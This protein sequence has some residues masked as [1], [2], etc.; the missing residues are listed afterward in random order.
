MS[1]WTKIALDHLEASLRASGGA[2]TPL[3]DVVL[4]RLHAMK[5]LRKKD[6]LRCDVAGFRLKTY[7]KLLDQ[8]M[9]LKLA[10]PPPK[11]KFLRVKTDCQ[12]RAIQALWQDLFPDYV[13]PPSNGRRTYTPSVTPR[14]VL[15]QNYRGNLQRDL[16]PMTTA[17]TPHVSHPPDQ[18]VAQPGQLSHVPD[19]ASPVMGVTPELAEP[20]SLVWVPVG[21]PHGV[22]DPFGAQAP[23]VQPPTYF[24]GWFAPSSLAYPAQP[25]AGLPTIPSKQPPLHDSVGQTS[26]GAL[27]PN[28]SWASGAAD[29]WEAYEAAN[30]V[31]YFPDRSSGQFHPVSPPIRARLSQPRLPP[32]RHPRTRFPAADLPAP[33]RGYL[34]EMMPLTS[35]SALPSSITTQVEA[36]PFHS[37]QGSEGSGPSEGEGSGLSEPPEGELPDVSQHSREE[38]SDSDDSVDLHELTV[39]FS[40]WAD[41]E[42]S[43]RIAGNIHQAVNS[44]EGDGQGSEGG[45]RP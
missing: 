26:D 15:S 43:T 35:G 28:A 39:L 23:A 1:Y 5:E 16:G 9:D 4:E 34:P 12:Q 18:H 30:P 33:T 7:E 11:K 31:V 32:R 45:R 20:Y 36:L 29:F 37:T 27:P 3:T 8:G 44:W 42:D 13:P 19:L 2:P 24:G 41:T 17:A 38:D 10:G 21:E 22:W 14:D 40:L 6:I 25:Q